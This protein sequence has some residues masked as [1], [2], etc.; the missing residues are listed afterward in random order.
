MADEREFPRACLLGGGGAYC[1]LMKKP[2]GKSQLGRPTRKWEENTK[3]NLQKMRWREWAGLNW[4]RLRTGGGCCE[5]GGEHSGTMKCGNC[6]LAK[7]LLVCYEGLWVR[8]AA[9]IHC[10]LERC[11]AGGVL[12]VQ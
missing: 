11:S 12:T 10:G 8:C 9:V 5:H 7:E 6:S 3:T 4:L 2:E 1:V